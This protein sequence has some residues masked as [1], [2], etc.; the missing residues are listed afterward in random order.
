MRKPVRVE[1]PWGGFV[2]Y[3]L[4]ERVTVKILT[5]E[6]GHEL[7]L[8]RHRMRDELWVVLDEGAEVRVGDRELRPG[9]GEEV[10]IPRGTLHRLRAGENRVR[11]LEISFGHFDEGD[12]ERLQDRYGRK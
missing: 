12:I 3:A 1:K 6:P 7:S 11:V 5:V 4:N 9:V 8:Q 10:W 2:Q